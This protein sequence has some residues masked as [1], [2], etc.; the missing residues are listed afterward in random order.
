MSDKGHNG[1]IRTLVCGSRF[2][3][4]YLEAV[5]ALPERFELAGLLA[6]GSERSRQCAARHGVPL[7]TQLDQL[8]GDI[9]LACVV[10]RSGVMG[11]DGT[12]LALALLESGISVLQE[13]PVH[14]QDMAACMK[15]ARRRG[16]HYA[17][18]E[19]YAH[20]PAVRSFTA[21]A[22]TLLANQQLLYIDAACATQVS[23]PL[24]HILMEAVPSIR[25]WK[26]NYI[27]EDEGP[28]QLVSGLLGGVPFTLRAHNEVDPYDSDNHLHLLHSLTIGTA[29]GRLSLVDTHG[30]VL[31]HPRLHVP[32]VPDLPAEL[33]KE[34]RMEER[35]AEILGSPNADTYRDVLLRQWTGAIGQD[36]LAM[37]D[38]LLGAETSDTRAQQELLCSRQWQE[39]T[40]ALGYQALRPQLAYQPLPASIL[41]EAAKL[42][43]AGGDEGWEPEALEQEAGL[44]AHMAALAGREATQQAAGEAEETG[45]AEKAISANLTSKAEK[46]NET[47]ETSEAIS[48]IIACAAG[49][50]AEISH[51]TAQQVSDCVERLDRAALLSMLHVLQTLGALP[52]EGVFRH[53]DDICEAARAAPRH[54]HLLR[55]WLRLLTSRGYLQQRWNSY[56]SAARIEKAYVS[57]CWEAARNAWENKLGPRSIIDYLTANADRL[58]ELLRDEQQAAQLLF[59]EGRMDIAG[60]LYRDTVMARY[61][62]KSVAEAVLRMAGLK[63]RHAFSA[64]GQA[65]PPALR[66]LELGAGTGATTDEVVRVLQS[67]AAEGVQ[68][69]YMF[70]DISRFFISAARERY[71]DCPWMDYQ[72]ADI[73]QSLTA[74]GLDPSSYDV[75]IAAGMLNN[76]RDTDAVVREMMGCLANDGWMLITEPT[77]EYTEMLI[78]QAFMMT[79]PED[80]RQNS[81][82]TFMSVE[83][84]LEVMRK[85]GAP[86]VKVLPDS[87]HALA[88][89]GQKLFIVRKGSHAEMQP[90]FMQS[91]QCS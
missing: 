62:N 83:Q 6:K 49:A 80:D 14:H 30:P 21:C 77:R 25:P 43:Q 27:V 4:F 52:E 63:R 85:A 29:A 51:L 88:P 74:Q 47:N 68:V 40:R 86:L 59:P 55:R 22:R 84:W 11:G 75:V 87:D 73:D 60:A 28:F 72:V 81:D 90:Y 3:Q 19:L 41:K 20:L 9:D 35:S 78:S 23:Y 34:A 46:G 1:T 64:P 56:A 32:D 91:G 57:K 45:E 15:V 7:Y 17:I 42:V 33:L 69:K 24:M 39:L 65:A 61:L 36:L 70:T 82:S 5:K 18:G 76:A 13:H 10:L 31:W 53:E 48:A 26:I 54:R 67:A 89:L 37:R 16:V 2:G 12:E 71:A 50:E 44:N 58:P 66:I 38:R 79:R 8:P